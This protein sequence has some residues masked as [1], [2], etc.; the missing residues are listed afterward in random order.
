MPSEKE[1]ERRLEQRGISRRQFLKY[2]SLVAGAIGIGPALGPKVFEAFAAGPRP[3]VVWLHFAECTGCTEATLRTSSPG[4]ADLIFETV[5]LEYH[6]TVMAAAGT[7]AEKTLYDAVARYPGEYF[8]VVEG[9]VPTAEGGIFGMVGGRTMIDVAREVYPVSKAVIALGTCAAFGGL[10]AAA[11]NPTGAKGVKDALGAQLGVPVVNISGCPP[12]P[13]NFV[14]TIADYL[15]N[16][17]LPALDS[18]GRPLFAYRNSVHSQCPYH[19]QE[20]RCLED[21]GCKGKR[22]H[23]NCPTHKFNEGTSWP[24]QAGHPCIGCSEPG[25]WDTMTPFYV[26]SNEHSGEEAYS[27]DGGSRDYGEY[28]ESDD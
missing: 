13:V 7:Q 15:L 6:E 26:E 21:S 9:A 19:E 4:F 18:L 2:C 27:G 14:G 12:N 10:A 16:G 28:G 24:V 23:N 25:F 22:C 17:R 11:P 5:S 3:P 1:F 8:C 20:S